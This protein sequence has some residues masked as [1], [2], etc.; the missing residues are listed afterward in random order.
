MRNMENMLQNKR[1]G[2]RHRQRGTEDKEQK[3]QRKK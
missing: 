2:K 3:K 1:G